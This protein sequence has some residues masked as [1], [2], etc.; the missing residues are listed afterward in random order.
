MKYKQKKCNNLRKYIFTAEEEN[1]NIYV[2]LLKPYLKF[3]PG[4]YRTCI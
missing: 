2:F 3:Y 1:E 4:D